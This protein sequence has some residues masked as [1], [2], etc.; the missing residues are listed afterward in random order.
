MTRTLSFIVIEPHDVAGSP[1]HGVL[2]IRDQLVEL[3][4]RLLPIICPHQ[5]RQRLQHG[6]V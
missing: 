3:F 2:P 1:R 4:V 5:V 6:E